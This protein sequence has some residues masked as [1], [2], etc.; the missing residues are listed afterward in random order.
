MKS[1][2][3]SFS[4]SHPQESMSQTE[5]SFSAELTS[6]S[7]AEGSNGVLER[8]VVRRVRSIKVRFPPGSPY[9]RAQLQHLL[10][11]VLGAFAHIVIERDL[12]TK[13]LQRI[14]D[15]IERDH[16]HEAGQPSHGGRDG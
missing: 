15:A 5:A 1:G 4:F 3:G 13:V 12:V 14:E 10:Q 2:S 9:L 11:R 16:L 6:R 8:G 7:K